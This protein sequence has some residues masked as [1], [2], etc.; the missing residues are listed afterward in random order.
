MARR[1]ALSALLIILILISFTSQVIPEH[2]MLI[3]EFESETDES[4][5][6]AF[7][8]QSFLNITGPILPNTPVNASWFAEVSVPESYGT[9]LLENRSLGLL[10]QIDVYLGNSDGWLESSESTAFA[11][12][13]SSARNWTNGET[14]G[15]CVFD[16]S[17]MIAMD[18]TDVTVSPPEEGPVNRT[19]GSWGWVESAVVSGSADGRVLRLIDLPRAG[20]VIEEVP[21]EVSLPDGWE[22]KYSP[23]AEIIEGEPNRFTVNRSE[24]PVAYDIRVTIGE[25]LPPT[26]SATRFPSTTAFVPLEKAS[27]FSASCS[28]SPLESPN[29]GWSVSRGG[30]ELASFQNSWFDFIPSEVGIYH[31]DQINVTATCTDFHGMTTKWTDSVT[32]DGILPEWEGHMVTVYEDD[33]NSHDSLVEIIEIPSGGTIILDINGTDDSGIPVR[34]DL[35][36]NITTDWRQQGEGQRTFQFTVFQGS[37]VNGADISIEDRHKPKEPTLTSVLLRVTDDAGNEVIHEWIVRVLDS[38]PP[39]IIAEFTSDGM[40]LDMND[41]IHEGQPL[42]LN[43]SQSFDDIDAID[44]LIWSAWVDGTPLLSGV[45][46]SE[47][48]SFDLPNISKGPHEVLVQSTDSNGNTRNET[49]QFTVLPKRGAHISI[50]SQSISVDAAVGSEATL[51]V[52]V[53]NEG[54]DPAFVRACLDSICSRFEQID[55]STLDSGPIRTPVELTFQVTN[56]TMTGLSIQWDSSAAGT[57]GQIPIELTIDESEDQSEGSSYAILTALLVVS[58]GVS[59]ALLKMRK[60][61]V[62]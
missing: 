44:S 29:I 55:G 58:V 18:G 42:Q 5:Q 20:S 27:S 23:M 8:G 3:G 11:D 49:I 46:W 39:T 4:N 16:Y 17:P 1:K 25:N 38:S 53:E 32:V 45:G 43:L 36:T 37:E 13:V 12:L 33:Q 14:A 47:I 40:A 54:T 35:F 51:T 24:A 26:I 56:Q 61:Q 34:L 2:R 57:S 59:A 19:G 9:E 7:H 48:E 52:L 21:L 50:V 30:E 10:G 28:D 62:N 15:C 31:G 60:K 6:I 41:G 22:F